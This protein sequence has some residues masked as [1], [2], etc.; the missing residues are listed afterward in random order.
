VFGKFKKKID[1]SKDSAKV[2][3]AT[4]PDATPR[5]TK[6]KMRFKGPEMVLVGGL[7]L[8]IGGMF[9]FMSDGL[10]DNT[11][12]NTDSNH[13]KESNVSKEENPP[14]V[15]ENN[16][17]KQSN[18]PVKKT[19]VVVKEE[20]PFVYVN[21]ADF[22]NENLMAPPE[23]YEQN[24]TLLAQKSPPLPKPSTPVEAP[25]GNEQK[26][27]TTQELSIPKPQT[28]SPVQKPI[29]TVTSSTSY[30]CS[31]LP[32]YRDMIGKEI[33]YYI[34]DETNYKYLPA[35]SQSNWDEAGILVKEKFIASRVD[36]DER[37]AEVSTGKWIPALE[38]MTC[39]L[40]QDG[41]L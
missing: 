15:Y 14:F 2:D 6:K 20:A 19:E 13:S 26:V 21:K 30:A 41:T 39:T 8:I 36:V 18:A 17:E 27:V 12:N 11:I 23:A 33:M 40:V 16:M 3:D 22:S 31:I 25:K 5:T 32:M 28:M 34:K 24:N 35:H 7:V 9:W 4:V 10:D 37:M 1:A 29:P 38:F